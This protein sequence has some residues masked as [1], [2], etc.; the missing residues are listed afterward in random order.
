MSIKYSETALLEEMLI[1]G[2]HLFHKNNLHLRRKIPH[3]FGEYAVQNWNFPG[4]QNWLNKLESSFLQLGLNFV[5]FENKYKNIDPTTTSLTKS[6]YFKSALDE[7]EKMLSDTN[8]MKLYTLLPEE[9]AFVIKNGKTISYGNRSHAFQDGN[10][11]K[12]LDKLWTTRKD[13]TGHND[14]S[15][16]GISMQ[17]LVEKLK[18]SEDAIKAASKAISVAMN[19]KNIPVSVR[20]RSKRGMTSLYIETNHK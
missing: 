9:K 11:I 6:N 12:L 3:T 15:S 4:R 8:Y 1:E 13:H 19:R 17:E 18:M 5:R 14:Q 16:G 2:Q 7:L 10:T 20:S